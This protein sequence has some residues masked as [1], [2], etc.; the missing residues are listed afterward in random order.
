MLLIPVAVFVIVTSYLNYFVVNAEQKE[1]CHP[2]ANKKRLLTVF[3][4][5]IKINGLLIFSHSLNNS[6]T[7]LYLKSSTN[8]VF[9]NAKYAINI[10]P[11]PIVPIQSLVLMSKCVKVAKIRES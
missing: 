6:I 7:L 10:R 8:T 3:L 2:L 4:T 11:T 1:W 5:Y 9:L